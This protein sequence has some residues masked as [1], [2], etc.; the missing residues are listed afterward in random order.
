[1]I[2]HTSIP[3][4][5][6]K[7]V[8]GVIAELW[9]GRFLPFPPY[10]GAYV[11]V[12]GDTRGTVIDVV[13]RGLEHH[14]AEGQFAVQINAKPS[15]YSHAH[16]AIGTLLSTEEIFRIAAREG[17]M[18]QRSDRGGLFEVIELWVENRFLLELLTEFQRRRYLANLTVDNL[19]RL[20]GSQE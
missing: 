1:V 20:I 13:P 5:D 15:P 16:A 9:H 12:A 10:P 7:R 6:P 18:A 4:D 2:F 14:P 8:A 3:A 17:W 19:E 11:A